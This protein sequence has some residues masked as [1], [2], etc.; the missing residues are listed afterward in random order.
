EAQLYSNIGQTGLTALGTDYL[1]SKPG[2]SLI[3]KGAGLVKDVGGAALNYLGIGSETVPTFTEALTPALIDA[4]GTGGGVSIAGELGSYI[5]E[6]AGTAEAGIGGVAAEG[7]AELAA[8]AATEAGSGILGTIGEGVSSIMPYAGYYGLAKGAGTIASM[9][10]KNNPNWAGTAPGHLALSLKEPLAVEQYWA[11]SLA[12]HGVGNARTNEIVA[13]VLNP[14]GGLITDT[15]NTAKMIATGGIS[16]INSDTNVPAA[17]LTGGVSAVLGTFVCTEL[18]RQGYLTEAVFKADA[19]FGSQMDK[20]EY[21]W[22]KTWGVPLALR[23]KKS[24]LIS[25]VVS[26]FMKPVSLYMAS[27]MGVG[28]G[29]LF[30]KINFKVLQLVCRWRNK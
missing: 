12:E 7:G 14:V 10:A 3:S 29:S 20:V 13:D 19:V 28:E 6:A 21:N 30:G 4:T 22:Y 18:Y 16:N 24:K 17:I 11:D 5:P 2:E 26:F 8:D 25:W 23:M 27:E 15:E 9:V 1:V